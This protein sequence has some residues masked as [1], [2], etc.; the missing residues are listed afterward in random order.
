[1]SK[2]EQIEKLT[3]SVEDLQER[4]RKTRLKTPDVMHLRL[5]KVERSIEKLS[6]RMDEVMYETGSY[7]KKPKTRDL[8][9]NMDWELLRKQKATFVQ[10]MNTILVEHE[11]LLDT[12]Q[13]ILHLIDAVQDHAVDVMGEP[14]EL[15]FGERKS[16]EQ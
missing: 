2:K 12:F 9:E 16:E 6:Q 11:H 4:L 3:A 10:V 13:G 1:M 8:F 7:R 14:E 5:E 15:V